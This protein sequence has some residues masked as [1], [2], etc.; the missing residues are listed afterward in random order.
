M[1]LR[2]LERVSE[3][4]ENGFY[5]LHIEAD[6]GATVELT[7]GDASVAL[8]QN[9]NVWSNSMHI[10]LRAGYSMPSPSRLRR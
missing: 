7:L 6:A 1:H 8:A 10:E 4:P 2:Y 5:N 9:G 3:V